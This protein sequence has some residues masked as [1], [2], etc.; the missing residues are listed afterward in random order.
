MSR[1]IRLPVVFVVVLIAALVGILTRPPGLLAMF[2]CANALLLGMMIRWPVLIEWPTWV[3]AAFAYVTADMATGNSLSMTLQLNG[4]N[5]L[6]VLAGVLLLRSAKRMPLRLADSQSLVWLVLVAAVSAVSTAATAGLLDQLIRDEPFFVTLFHWASTEFM[7]YLLVLP[8]VLSVGIPSGLAE[9]RRYLTVKTLATMAVPLLAT[10]ACVP[11]AFNIEGPIALV[12]PLPALLWCATRISVPSTALVSLVWSVW[13]LMMAGSGRLAIGDANSSRWNEDVVTSIAVTLIALG[14]IAVAC[15]TQERRAA[16]RELFL[17]V[18]YDHLTGVL[19]R[20]SFLRHAEDELSYA[21]RT[22]SPAG[23]LMLDLD[24]FKCINDTHGHMGGD[25]VLA[26]F[27][28]RTA[29]LLSEGD[30]VGRLGGEE[31]AV[32]L[33]DCSF[34]R[35]VAVSESIRLSQLEYSEAT[36]ITST[37]SI[38]VAWVDHATPTLPA[39]MSIADAALYEAK[40]GGRNLVK[41]RNVSNGELPQQGPE[42]GTQTR[43]FRKPTAPRSSRRAFDRLGTADGR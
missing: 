9:L 36:G 22:K 17:A 31:F 7:A 23:M 20:G 25:V 33:L 11:I 8:F 37:V 19:S 16:E 34:T 24:H 12:L 14:P 26:D 32:L 27:A 29:G 2:W 4:A 13:A 28:E 18:E 15:A 1:S 38:G 30:L 6:G 40:R 35:A 42:P 3:T 21:A 41:A 39:L 43:T 5:L 10:L